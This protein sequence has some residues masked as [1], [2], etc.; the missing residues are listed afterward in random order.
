MTAVSLNAFVFICFVFFYQA[1][2]WRLGE[3]TR[4]E[5]KEQ[6]RLGREIKAW[7]IYVFYFFFIVCF[8]GGFF[9]VLVD[10][11]RLLLL[12]MYTYIDNT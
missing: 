11:G 10:V 5:E 7:G 2:A 12:D 3:Y 4:E 1:W 6:R 9:F 8:S